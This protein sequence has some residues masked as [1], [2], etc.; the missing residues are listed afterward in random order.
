MSG[1]TGGVTKITSSRDQ[2]HSPNPHYR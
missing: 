2:G 1:A